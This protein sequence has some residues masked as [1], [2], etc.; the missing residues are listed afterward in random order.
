[1]EA[2]R[3]DLPN[4]AGRVQAD[5]VARLR[6]ELDAA[7]QE[8]EAFL[9]AVSHDLRAPVRHI[10]AYGRLLRETV[11][12][13]NA[14]PEALQFLDTIAQAGQQLGGMIDGLIQ[15]GRIGAAPATPGP[16]ALGPVLQSA[17]A[18]ARTAAAAAPSPKSAAAKAP[19]SS[20]EGPAGPWLDAVQWD[21]PAAEACPVLWADA[22]WLQEVLVALLD[23]ALKFSRGAQPPRIAVH[24]RPAPGDRVDITVR[25]NGAGFPAAQ[26][27]QLFQVFQRLHP[28]SQFEGLG[29]G[30]ARCRRLVAR[31][32]GTIGISAAPHQGCTVCLQLP[33]AGAPGPDAGTG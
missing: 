5:E 29:L 1:M 13:S 14:D 24:V 16:V 11:A 9:R 6:M 10:L 7:R 31:M 26:A 18:A 12:E 32:G 33:A 19:A 2:P 3:S 20:G 23:N 4:E 22:G 15:L 28:A 30:L 25:D 8:Q 27:G 21:L 17:V